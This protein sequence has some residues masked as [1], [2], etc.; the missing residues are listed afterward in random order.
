MP[1]IKASLLRNPIEL[2]KFPKDKPGW[3]RWWAPDVALQKLLG[4]HYA[5][6][7]PKL[8]QGVGPLDGQSCI[9]VGVAI[10]ESIRDRLNWHVNQ[11]HTRSC[12]KHGTLSTLRQSIA[13][14]VGTCQAD[15]A[16]TN[17]IID[18]LTIEYFPVDLPIK[19]TTAK[20]CID[21]IEKDEMQKKALPLNIQSNHHKD[22]AIFKPALKLAR[23]AAKQA[24]LQ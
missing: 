4:Q 2:A 21:V 11:Q 1:I 7:A 5:A 18:L 12:V 24:Y 14:L 19:S 8:T 15:E 22:V 6:L 16:A 20:K 13:S 10:K 9:Y 23:K 3:Y 17:R